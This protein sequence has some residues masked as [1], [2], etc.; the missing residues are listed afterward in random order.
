MKDPSVSELVEN[1]GTDIPM[2]STI[3]V[4]DEINFRKFLPERREWKTLSWTCDG[5]TVARRFFES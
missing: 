3:F 1:L 5:K 2:G 4:F